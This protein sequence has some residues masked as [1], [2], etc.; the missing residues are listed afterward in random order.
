MSTYHTFVDGDF[1]YDRCQA[2][3]DTTHG[4]PI[5]VDDWRFVV[6]AL[7][8]TAD[9]GLWDV[10]EWDDGEWGELEWS[11]MTDHVRGVEWTRGADEFYGRP[12][13]GEARITLSARCGC[14]S[15]WNPDPPGGSSAYFAPGTIVRAGVVSDVDTRA[16]GWLPQFTMI[17]DAWD[18]QD[19]D[20]S[21]GADTIVQIIAFETLRD[22]AGI[23]DNALPGV[24]GGG[25]TPTERFTRL[26]E[27]AEWPYG[28][29]INATDIV[30]FDTYWALQSTD[31]A[32]N[33]LAELYL[34]ADSTDCT[35]RTG[36]KGEAFIEDVRLRHP[37]ATDPEWPLGAFSK[38][39]DDNPWLAFGA[40]LDDITYIVTENPDILR[41]PYDADTAR[42]INDDEH[43]VND[44][45]FTR[46]GGTQ[47][48]R[49][50]PASISRFGRRTLTRTDLLNNADTPTDLL[51]YRVVNRRGR[52]TL[53]V[54]EVTVATS[55][56]GDDEYLAVAAADIGSGAFV[57]PPR[58]HPTVPVLSGDIENMTHRITARNGSELTWQTMFGFTTDKVFRLPAAILPEEDY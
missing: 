23:D 51:A 56:R 45:R 34:T 54:A 13:I 24:V 49:E 12:R 3:P 29:T 58:P 32:N 55:D 44:A 17:V 26:L 35:F 2:K 10:A 1:I 36:R 52:F 21:T 15:P 53:R 33:R 14:W 40:S 7:L 8:P 47:Q 46:A 31:M 22:L 9:A 6:E 16:G 27:A 57:S 11:D 38:V 28:L 43:L 18:E 30:D 5:G 41:V 37:D 25:D 19:A 50:H 42:T 39:D 4:T 20:G 48:V